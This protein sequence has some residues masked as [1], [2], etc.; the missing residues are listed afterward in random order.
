MKNAT[1]IESVAHDVKT[2]ADF[3]ATEESKTTYYILRGAVAEAEGKTLEPYGNFNLV[4]STGSVYV[5]GVLNNLKDKAS[6]QFG[7]LN[8]AVG[9]TITIMGYHTSHSGS[10]QVGGAIFIKNEKKAAE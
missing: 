7:T 10:A 9:D 1:L 5:Y 2:V 6:K 4:D 8:V 3:L